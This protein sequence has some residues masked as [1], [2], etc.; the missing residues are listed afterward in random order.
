VD[1]GIIDFNAVLKPEE[2]KPAW[3]ARCSA[4]LYR[5][6]ETEEAG[7]VELQMGSDD[8][9]RLWLNG[10]LIVESTASRGLN[11][12]DHTITLNLS[13]GTNHILAKIV[14]GDG[15]WSYQMRSWDGVPYRAVNEAIDRGV[16][17]LLSRQLVDGSWASHP[18][19]GAGYTAYATYTLL[20]CGLS[21]KHPAIRRA[22]TF[23]RTRPADH[24]Y[25][26]SCRILALATLNDEQD[27]ELL[28]GDL[29][30]LLDFQEGTGLYAYPV[31]P[32]GSVLPNDLSCTLFATLALRAADHR[33]VEVPDRTWRRLIQGTL[34]CQGPE[35]MW[36]HPRKGR[37]VTSPFGYRPH[38]GYRG[39][40]TSAGAS[41]L[42][43]A[44]E[45]LGDHLES[46]LKRKAERGI[47]GGLAWIEKNMT[48]QMNPG[49]GHHYFHIY[50]M[51]RLGSLMNKRM[52]GG[53]EWYAT[54]ADYLLRNQKPDGCWVDSLVD[55]ALALLFLERATAPSTGA[56]RDPDE[57]LHISEPMETGV[58]FRV[59]AKTP[60][61]VWIT[62]FGPATLAELEWTHERGRGP[63]VRYAEFLVK[64]PGEVEARM[65][66]RVDVDPTVPLG[67]QRL[68]VQLD[69]PI[70]GT[71][72]FQVRVCALLEPLEEGL[73]DLIFVESAI[74]SVPLE[75]GFPPETFEYCLDRDL[76]LLPKTQPT[77]EASSQSGSGYDPSQVLDGRHDTRWECAA[78]DANPTLKIHLRRSVRAER[79]L[80]S[81]AWARLKE[82]TLARVE[83]FEVILNE[84]FAHTL[85]MDPHPLRKTELRLKKPT[86]IRDIE[87]RILK[88]R[89]GTLG[90]NKVGF[91]EVQLLK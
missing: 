75:G 52:L 24:T 69:L 54:G 6:L 78:D 89:D 38:E 44:I 1:V 85:E 37:M 22:M 28:Q 25:S 14:N 51:E 19:Y 58:A 23:V 73:E 29:E 53:V 62:G 34:Q 32:G 79:L 39:S 76:N 20:K 59:L 18:E 86:K 3:N 36:K 80:F 2:P 26:L 27:R 83:R 47:E 30:R 88:V 91:S 7:T 46:G 50:G 82:K 12:T 40:M 42:H 49:G 41:I 11:A 10:Q 68:S 43:I 33:G 77:A 9:L 60:I 35:E 17:F 74:L 31:H 5:V 63:R 55:T 8:G 65:V 66:Q 84:R 67:A 90:Q 72:E 56:T 71:H 61:V 16:K 87:I 4:Y 45:E 57:R 64:E 13:Q 15:G 81:H 21:P 70:T 48:W